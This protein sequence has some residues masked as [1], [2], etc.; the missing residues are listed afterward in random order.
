M[1][2]GAHGAEAAAQRFF[3]KPASDLSA[4]E[5]AMLAGLLT[6]PTTYAPT[7]DLKRS[8]D[9]AATVLRLMREQGLLSEAEAERAQ[10]RPAT[11]S[12]AAQARAGG[13]FADWVMTTGPDFFT[14]DTT[15]DVVIRTTF[16]Q[17]MQTAAEDA[18]DRIFA[19]KV[20][21][22]SK[23]EA[24]IVVMSS[25]GAVRAMVGGRQRGAGLF[26]R[27]VQAERQT[28]SA[29][30]PFVYATALDLGWS[31]NDMIVD[32]PITLN[33]PGSGPWSP[34]NYTNRFYGP[35]TLTAALENSLN[36]PAVK[37]SEEVGRENVRTVA[38]MFGLDSDLA[39]GPALALGASESTL[40]EMTGAY[41]GILNGGSAV[42]PYGLIELRLKGESEALMDRTGGIGERVIQESAASQLVWMMQQVVDG[43]TGERAQVP[44]WQIA[45]KTGTTQ[46]AR[47]AWFV[48]FSAD[49]VAGVWMGYDD[50]TPL[51]GVTGGGL[52]AEIFREVMI[53]IHAGLPPRPLPGTAPEPARVATPAPQ[54]APAAPAPRQQRRQRTIED[55]AEDVLNKAMEDLFGHILR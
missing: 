17:R 1:G 27:A 3:D 40:L 29:F 25:D 22:G 9:R 46:A 55:V 43:G 12:E 47:D 21:E 50:N 15:E 39:A 26:N 34:K 37:L 31:P 48:G 45:G 54:P 6:A 2:G 16:D 51:S 7:N 24:A 30:K 13:A 5:G 49:Y 41:A 28:G 44:G 23:A 53:G 32:E 52:P 38:A 35:V 14:R 18:L 36:I 11:L 19:T 8:Q 42:D 10:A 20:R 33:I 4:A